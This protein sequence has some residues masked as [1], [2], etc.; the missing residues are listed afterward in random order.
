[1]KIAIITSGMLPVPA[2]QGGAV[3]NL[4]DYLLQYNNQYH[5]HDITVYSIYNNK[6]EHQPALQSKVNHYVYI[7][8]DSL[9]FKICA[10]IY[11]KRPRLNYYYY[12]I[13][14]FLECVIKKMKGSSYDLIISENRPGFA[15]RLSDSFNTP[16]ITHI[17]TNLLHNPSEENL[18]AIA[19]SKA[20][21]VVSDYIKK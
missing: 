10:K 17:H 13:E 15:I 19:A 1:M 14:Y 21:I 2:V 6:V 12:R 18:K 8:T 5:L 9:Y 11:S 3:E 16:I 4:I 20:F 7:N